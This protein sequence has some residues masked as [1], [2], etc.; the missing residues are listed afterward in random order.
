MQKRK[1]KDTE[2]FLKIQDDYEQELFRMLG[3]KDKSSKKE[4]V[5]V[6]D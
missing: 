6:N 3:Q 4:K 2:D 5:K 1:N